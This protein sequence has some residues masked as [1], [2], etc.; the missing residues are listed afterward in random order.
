MRDETKKILIIIAIAV[1]INA[2]A[3]IADLLY[4]KKFV[5]VTPYK[6][7]CPI[8]IGRAETILHGGMLYRDIPTYT[9]PLINYIMAIPI[10]INSSCYSLEIFFS[11][12]NVI[13]SILLFIS[14]KSYGKLAFY[15]A[16][17]YS[18]HPLT[19][20]SSIGV[21]DEPITAFFILLSVYFLMKD[22]RDA[23]AI[24]ISL[25]VWIKIFPALIFPILLIRDKSNRERVKHV[26]ILG[27]ISAAITFPFLI[28]AGDD[29]TKFLTFYIFGYGKV[30]GISPWHSIYSMFNTP[31]LSYIS[32]IILII[33][34]LIVYAWIKNK[35]YTPWK[36]ALLI[37]LV[38]FMFY[39]K[40]H[41]NYFLYIFIL[42]TP[43]VF[44]DKKIAWKYGAITFLVLLS[45]WTSF[46]HEWNLYA[47]FPLSI[48]TVVLLA[49]IFIDVTNIDFT[50]LKN[51]KTYNGRG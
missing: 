19:F 23:A 27:G 42:L 5:G 31:L 48:L 24:V 17:L 6:C 22:K 20:I 18:L 12:F 43:F 1:A 46:Q 30:I 11:F 10:A 39:R 50:K 28:L 51:K 34:M 7:D 47:F 8:F 44:M 21:Q 36:S 49:A 9:P 26:G 13:S 16:I 40:I 38:F 35:E 3:F 41:G 15:S 45:Q 29:F 25:G 32:L 4:F 2:V 14:L 37:F 33:G